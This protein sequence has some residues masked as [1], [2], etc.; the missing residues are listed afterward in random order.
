MSHFFAPAGAAMAAMAL[1]GADALPVVSH[2][3]LVGVLTRRDFLQIGVPPALLGGARPRTSRFAFAHRWR[4][5]RLSMAV[6]MS[7]VRYREST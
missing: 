4:Y 5:S 3:Y 6:D 7:R 2:G 1:L